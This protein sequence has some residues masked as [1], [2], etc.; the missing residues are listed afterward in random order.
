M[1]RLSAGRPRKFAEPSRAVTVT[2]PVRILEMLTELNRDRARAIA[3]ATE[4]ALAP[5][6]R[7]SSMRVDVVEVAPEIGLIVVGPSR[8]LLRIPW[9]R[10]AEI[11]PGRHIITILPGTS[12]ETLELAIGDILDDAVDSEEDEMATLRDLLAWIRTLRRAH[13]LTK[14][15]L[16]F[17]SMKDGN[18]R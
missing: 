7:S 15:E 3:R 14:A 18:L 8:K 11:A 12:I 16:L 9:L 5:A 4:S 6:T 13:H 17:V 1:S 10:L 2:L